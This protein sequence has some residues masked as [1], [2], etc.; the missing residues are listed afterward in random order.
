MP[1]PT[2]TRGVGADM[3]KNL[4]EYD[5]VLNTQ[6]DKVYSL[7]RQA[8]VAP[9]LREQMLEFSSRTMDDILEVGCA[10]TQVLALLCAYFWV[11]GGESEV[12]ASMAYWR[13]LLLSS[14]RMLGATLH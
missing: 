10:S 1:G 9:D 11:D 3:R 14:Y 7:R 13:G 12:C 2:L 4:F 8:L 6:R 5:Q